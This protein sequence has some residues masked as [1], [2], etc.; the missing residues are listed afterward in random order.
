MNVPGFRLIL[1]LLSCL[2]STFSYGANSIVGW[3]N[4]NDGQVPPPP[5]LANVAAVAAGGIH[6]LALNSNGT[7]VAWGSGFFGQT[8][9]PMNLTNA[10][11]IAGGN[12]YSLALRVDGTMTVW[13]MHP[14]PPPG[15]NNITA[16]AAGWEHSLA[17]KSDST[18]VAW[19]SDNF[20]PTNLTNVTSVAAGNGQSLALLR[21]STVIAWGDNAFGKANV[22]AGLTNVVAIAAGQDHCLA[23]RQDGTVVAWGGD[24]NGQATV[25]AGLT[26][27]VAISAGA[28]H[29]IALKAN[30]T[31]VAWGDN[32]F[33]Q[34]TAPPLTNFFAISAGGYHNL[35]LRGDGS[36]VIT[37]PPANQNIGISFN[38]AFQVIAV[39]AQP[40]RYQWQYYSTNIPGATN[41]TLTLNNVQPADGGPYRVIVSNSIGSTISANAILT[42]VGI[43]PFITSAPQD[44]SVNCGDDA[45][46]SGAGD[47]SKPLSYQWLFEG[48]DIA[49]QTQPDLTLVNISNN[50]AGL[51]SLL[52]SNDF[53]SV[54][55]APARLTVIPVPP[56]ITS[57]LT[58]TG[59]QG[60]PFTYTITG[61]HTPTAFSAGILPPGLSIDTNTGVISGS[62]LES[63]TF[64]S[65]ITAINSCASDSQTLVFT[66]SSSI[67]VI[68]SALSAG[69]VEGLPFT[70]RIRG[71]DSP[72]SFGA[73]NLP[74]G[75]TVNPTNGFITGNPVY[76][77]DFFST[78]SASNQWGVGSATLYF[79]FTNAPISGL[80]I[81]NITYNYSSPYLLDFGFSLR[82]NV[83]PALG[84]A[85]VTDPKLLSVT[86]LED[87]VPISP[88]E[89]AFIVER[90]TSKQFKTH[91]VLD[92]SESIASLANGDSNG[93]GISDAVEGMVAGAINFV[94]QQRP[95]AQ[96]GVFE[97]HRE[98]MDPQKV[99]GLTAD[100]ALLNEAIAGIWENYVQ[101]FPAGSRAWDA[102]VAA[103]NDLGPTNRD[104]QHYIVFVSDGKDESSL[105][106]VNNVIDAAT[107]AAVKLYC[108]GFGAELDANVLQ[109]I[110]SATD[111]RYYD[112][113]AVG[114]LT[115]AFDQIGKDLNG[116]Y[117]LR[118]ATLKRLNKDF[119]PSFEISFQGITAVT[120]PNPV[121]MD[122]NVD[123]STMPPTTNVTST[124]NFII[125]P[126]NPASNAAPVT[127]GSLR[128][129]A[130]AEAIPK[131]VTLRA[132]YV[133]RYI[134]QLRI[135]YRP[136][137]PCTTTL[138][139][140][141]PGEIL[142]GW[143]LSETND[144]AGG[145]WLE[146]T[147]P[148]P[149][150]L[151]NS[152]AFGA[153]GN[154]VRFT[155]R[156]ALDTTNAFSLFAVDNT[157]YTNTGNQSFV[158]ENTNAFITI[159]PATP[160]GTPVPWLIAHGYSNNF[161]AA[162][163]ADP[164]GDGVPNWQEYAANTDPRD[165]ASK[166][167]VRPLTQD[168]YAR[169]QITFSTSSGRTYRVDASTD[170][171][172]WDVVQDGIL[173]IGAEVTIT[174]RRY[175]SGLTQ[176]F[177]R[178]AVY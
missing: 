121:T 82:D 65:T 43:V 58:A 151:T 99:I 17:L 80:S 105:N 160:Y 60:R 32:T 61:M 132:S 133:P 20:V 170:L 140:N 31:L 56:T 139:S 174:D 108:I 39:G 27:V 9:V 98:D 68:T 123:N 137:W 79:S 2:L 89:T 83:D 164:D 47:G 169:N 28:H 49:G 5:G 86:C 57:S 50:N 64:G 167:F 19:G 87:G 93:D 163:L 37:V 161:P 148:D 159:Y 73:Q 91:L 111:G 54:T 134:R 4:G 100:G 144:G 147:S 119:M 102:L 177:Y 95:G 25:P 114:G 109:S 21:D 117:L 141:G 125:G 116:Q 168:A 48:A 166:F 45:T 51:Y 115:A 120:P 62:P 10:A 176:I 112:A 157:V 152:I 142:A 35:A 8:T 11:A 96:V 146:I 131:S 138:L 70:Y 36:P 175:L 75:L 7:V 53:G 26:G 122:T 128:L 104:E 85:V 92:F 12:F 172:S 74:L 52:V 78:I 154:L 156:D 14:Q 71:T 150:Y 55:S 69:G 162:E 63:G 145:R 106:T 42:P 23:L 135:H 101:W 88:S 66:F 77:G 81:A 129:I 143:T 15:L 38:G 29:S 90:G 33:G 149:Q 18:V 40:L 16:I 84:N 22:P 34:G 67:P 59:K 118:W 3:G 24:Y 44:Q 171:V 1:T 103:I 153:L 130:D 46:F 158:I 107:N 94:D 127:V 136:N 13:G 124:T 76:A 41:A 113:N 178:V 155:L 97:F 173:G 30:G 165:A 6:S 110:T 126:Y 72:T